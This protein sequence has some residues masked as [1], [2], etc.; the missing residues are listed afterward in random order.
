M[1]PVQRAVGSSHEKGA[2][3]FSWCRS[4]CLRWHRVR[5]QALGQG[6]EGGVGLGLAK[7]QPNMM[8]LV[9]AKQG[10]PKGVPVGGLRGHPED[11][12]K[13]GFGAFPENGRLIYL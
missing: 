7:A 12:R 5:V 13:G 2:R 6:W 9:G 4:W 8:G 10:D 11:P 3:I 1:T